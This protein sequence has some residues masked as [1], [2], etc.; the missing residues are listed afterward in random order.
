[1]Q[2]DINHSAAFMIFSF[3]R[4][5]KDTLGM[6]LPV[7][8]QRFLSHMFQHYMSRRKTRMLDYSIIENV[9]GFSLLAE[10]LGQ[11]AGT[12]LKNN[13]TFL[14]LINHQLRFFSERKQQKDYLYYEDEK[15][16]LEVKT[17]F[18]SLYEQVA[19]HYHW[20][21]RQSPLYQIESES[22]IVETVLFLVSIQNNMDIKKILLFTN[23]GPIWTNFLVD[24]LRA[25]FGRRI[26][27]QTLD[28][29]DELYAID[30]QAID[31]VI[32]DTEIEK[33]T[34]PLVVI[35]PLPSIRDFNTI[36]EMLVNQ[37]A[38]GS[39]QFHLMR[40]VDGNI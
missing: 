38:K 9:E 18:K 13:Q 6:S 14:D 3:N 28:Y 5:L 15:L 35:T 36:E 21:D 40:N 7:E 26:E 29:L 39:P 33:L 4:K 34:K 17:R 19:T 24:L 8:E 37:H 10:K 1:M 2:E 23:K 16:F 27:I 22:N 31:F 32:S 20:F 30:L 12:D 11:I 25:K